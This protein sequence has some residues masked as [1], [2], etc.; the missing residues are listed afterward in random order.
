[1]KKLSKTK[2]EKLKKLCLELIKE[3]NLVFFDELFVFSDIEPAM[4]FE[5]GLAETQSL[6]DALEINRA[7]LKRELRLKWFDSTNATLNAAL[8]KLVCTEDEKRALSSSQ[9]QKSSQS[10]E[11]CTQEE[12]LRSLKEMGE[13]L[14]TTDT[15]TQEMT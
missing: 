10:P 12:Y 13:S 2:T 6:K 4:F 5:S 8:Y 11:V 9:S 3:N 1:M 15:E 7:K 14:N